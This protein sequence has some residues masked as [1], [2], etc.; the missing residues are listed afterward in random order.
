MAYLV[1][2]HLSVLKFWLLCLIPRCFIWHVTRFWWYTLFLECIQLHI[3][4]PSHQ[5]DVI[6]IPINQC[7]FVCQSFFLVVPFAVPWH[8]NGSFGAGAPDFGSGKM[9]DY[10]YMWCMVC[11]EYNVW[12]ILKQQNTYIPGTHL[13]IVLPQ[14]RSFP[15][16]TRD[17]WV[18]GTYSMY[19]HCFCCCWVYSNR[20]SLLP[21]SRECSVSRPLLTS[22]VD[23]GMMDFLGSETRVFPLYGEK[24][25]IIGLDWVILCGWICNMCVCDI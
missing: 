21:T 9:L 12:Y 4:C 17:V 14:G 11:L 24:L 22:D 5:S 3:L 8:R 18:P 2:L 20:K 15:I 13:S 25:P 19:H 16:K 10:M 1:L 23:L 7:V 6:R